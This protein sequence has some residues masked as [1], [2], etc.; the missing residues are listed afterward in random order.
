MNFLANGT[1]LCSDCA[2]LWSKRFAQITESH[3][4]H[5]NPCGPI[6]DELTN[7]KNLR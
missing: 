3:F 5:L 1:K 6:I 4:A 2:R 7:K